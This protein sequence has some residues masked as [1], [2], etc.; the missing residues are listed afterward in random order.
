MM[1]DITDDE[2]EDIKYRYLVTHNLDASQYIIKTIHGKTSATD[3]DK[4]LRYYLLQNLVIA[5]MRPFL[6]SR[7]RKLEKAELKTFPRDKVMFVREDGPCRAHRISSKDYVPTE[8]EDLHKRLEVFRSQQFAHTD[9][10]YHNIQIA[11]MGT[12]KD[13]WWIFGFK[14]AE[15]EWLDQK[16]PRIEEL[17]N[18]IHKKVLSELD[19]A[20]AALEKRAVPKT[21]PGATV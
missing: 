21:G 7:G 4:G 9:L 14:G 19:A 8:F 20:L 2:E 11:N 18:I 6:N 16:F 13:P 3:Q 1:Y 17:V 5:Y 12:I 10:A 15:L